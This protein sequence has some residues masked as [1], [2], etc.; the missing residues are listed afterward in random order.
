[1]PNCDYYATLEDH[2]VILD[3]LFSQA[4]VEIY[5][6]YS[7]YE[8]PLQRF[9][10]TDDVLKEFDNIYTTGEKWKTVY[11]NLNI[12][13]SNILFK[14]TDV[15]LDPKQCNGKKY[16]YAAEGFG[17][18]QLY[19]SVESKDE[20]KDSHTNHSSQKRS[21]NWVGI[22]T[23]K[24]KVAE[25]NFKAINSFSLKFNREIKKMGVAKIG[26]R[27]L[28][29]SALSLWNQGFSLSPFTHE[30]ASIVMIEK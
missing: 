17:L 21:E 12:K 16:R 25:T 13:E 15:K 5:E 9:K 10:N 7:K 29:R 26:S 27:I 1:M 6:L 19:L 11:L 4:N 24:E 30:N 22:S 8:E 18:I 23:T 14:P 3:Y 20:L 2:R 28:T